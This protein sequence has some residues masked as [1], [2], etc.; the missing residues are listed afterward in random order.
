MKHVSPRCSKTFVAL[1]TPGKLFS[2]IATSKK[3]FW[4]GVKGHLWN[5]Q[6]NANPSPREASESET[7]LWK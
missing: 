6:C 7:H 2:G 4:L 5:K 1:D 3:I